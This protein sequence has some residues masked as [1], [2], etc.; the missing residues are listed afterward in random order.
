[1]SYTNP[2]GQP[3]PVFFYLLKQ[4]FMGVFTRLLFNSQC[5][6][7]SS[8]FCYIKDWDSPWPPLILRFLFAETRY[9][10]AN[11]KTPVLNKVLKIE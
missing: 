3:F 11:F 10:V 5:G 1:M 7:T 2:V 6:N 4:F 9:F 8:Y